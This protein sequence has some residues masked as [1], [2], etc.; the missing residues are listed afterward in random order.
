MSATRFG[1]AFVYK[2][3][4]PHAPPDEWIRVPVDDVPEA[5]RSRIPALV[6]EGVIAKMSD[7]DT[8]W[9]RAEQ[10]D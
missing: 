9:W 6:V 1:I 4:D 7:D 3:E 5:V 8:T 10:Y 2:S